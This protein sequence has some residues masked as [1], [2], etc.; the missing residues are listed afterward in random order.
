VSQLDIMDE[1]CRRLVADPVLDGYSLTRRD[2]DVCVALCKKLGSEW[3]EA[4]FLTML[5]DLE[6]RLFAA[7]SRAGFID[8][9]NPSRGVGA[10]QWTKIRL[11]ESGQL[12]LSQVTK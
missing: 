6:S 12:W 4:L 3:R 11:S 1:E 5:D 8:E 10:F 2:F 9:F 7:C